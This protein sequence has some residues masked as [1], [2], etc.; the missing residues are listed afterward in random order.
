MYWCV[1]FCMGL[2]AF[3]C[4]R[5]RLE[6]SP[7]LFILAA[8]PVMLGLGLMVLPYVIRREV[9]RTVYAITNRRVLVC[10]KTDESWPL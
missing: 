10:A 1:C 3:V 8:F 7:G 2:A 9:R 6:E 4:W 5:A